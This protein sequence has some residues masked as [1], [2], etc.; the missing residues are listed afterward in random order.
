MN[1]YIFIS[2]VFNKA[3]SKAMFYSTYT[4]LLYLFLS[5]IPL[6]IQVVFE[7]I[8]ST[9]VLTSQHSIQ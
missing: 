1:I 2:S 6:L 7:K 8:A 4:H 9:Y 3:F 5:C